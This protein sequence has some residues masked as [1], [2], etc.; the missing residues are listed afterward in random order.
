LDRGRIYDFASQ[1]DKMGGNAAADTVVTIR[2]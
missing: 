2:S 1:I